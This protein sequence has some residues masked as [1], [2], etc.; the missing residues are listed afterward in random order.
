MKIGILSD[1]HRKVGRARRI[2]E[3]LVLE[4]AEAFIHAGDV[5]DPENLALLEDTGLPY[6]AV[7]GNNDGAL[8]H[9]EECY[10]IHREPYRF[11]M[12]GCSFRLMHYPFWLAHAHEDI[13]IYGHTHERHIA[14]HKPHLF[15]NPG[16]AC[17][18]NKRVSEAM[19]LEILPERF[20]VTAYARILKTDKWECDIQEFTR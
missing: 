16:E 19:M 18:R 6:K 2:I 15:L 12:G 3:M 8:A 10:D 13:V 4:G 17:A 1:T 7:F 20:I 5:V 9:L 11:T 14:W